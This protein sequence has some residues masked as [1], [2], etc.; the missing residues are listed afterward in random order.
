M[1]WYIVQAYSGFEKKV[2]DSIK[3][4]LSKKKT[5]VKFRTDFSSNTPSYRGKKREEDEKRKKVFSRLC[6]SKG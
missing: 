6:F 2:V 3:D 4:T 1:N 5:R